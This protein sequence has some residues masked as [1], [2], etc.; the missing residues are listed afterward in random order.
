MTIF[1]HDKEEKVY[2][3]TSSMHGCLIAAHYLFPW[4]FFSIIVVYTVGSKPNKIWTYIV[5]Q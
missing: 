1:T 4:P 2:T 3:A 5:Q